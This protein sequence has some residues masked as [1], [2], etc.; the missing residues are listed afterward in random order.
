MT[1]NFRKRRT[2]TGD[3]ETKGCSYLCGSPYSREE[4][5]GE[6]KCYGEIG[7]LERMNKKGGSEGTS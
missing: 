5:I 3:R 4:R 2:G 7:E 1:I 6:M